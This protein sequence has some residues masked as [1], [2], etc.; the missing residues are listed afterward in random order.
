MKLMTGASIASIFL[1]ISSIMATLLK[2]SI[3]YLQEL[4][5]FLLIKVERKN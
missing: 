1:S 3:V 5:F 4:L 2:E